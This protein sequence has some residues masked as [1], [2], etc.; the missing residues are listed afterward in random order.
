MA[1]R[2]LPSPIS[3]GSGFSV[4]RM[5]VPESSGPR[6]ASDRVA[7]SRISG[8]SEA[9]RATMPTMPHTICLR[10]SFQDIMSPRFC[11]I[12][13]GSRGSFCCSSDEIALKRC[14]GVERNHSAI[15]IWLKSVHRGAAEAYRLCS[16][17]LAFCFH[18]HALATISFKVRLAFQPSI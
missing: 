15:K 6:W 8:A 11:E 9:F 2:R 13:R 5:V 18:F 12:N 4:R 10:K 17:R 16:C 14:A 1:R 7:R 3:S